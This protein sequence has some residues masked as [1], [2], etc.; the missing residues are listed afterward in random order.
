MLEFV[1]NRQVRTFSFNPPINLSEERNWLLAVSSFDCTK[2][3]LNRTNEN[4]SFSITI[5]GHWSSESA[6][7]TIDELNKLLELRSQNYF[8]IQVKAV[9]KKGNQIKIGNKK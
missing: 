1:T 4:K 2:Y 8:E 3:V 9:R 6:E 7:K 5:L